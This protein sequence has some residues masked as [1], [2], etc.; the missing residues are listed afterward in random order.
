MSPLFKVTTPFI[1]QLIC[2]WINNGGHEKY[3]RTPHTTMLECI[4]YLELTFFFKCTAVIPL[5]LPLT[6]KFLAI[7]VPII[8]AVK[9]DLLMFEYYYTLII[10]QIK[11]VRSLINY[12]LI[13]SNTYLSLHIYSILLLFD[14]SDVD[15]NCHPSNSFTNIKNEQLKK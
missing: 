11:T 15:A 7:S 1:L 9:V 14:M 10:S 8:H 12:K 4:H 5:A 13:C 6:F 3:V 2:D